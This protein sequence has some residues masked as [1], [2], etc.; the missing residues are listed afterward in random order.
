MISKASARE[1]VSLKTSDTILFG[2]YFQS[3]VPIEDLSEDIRETITGAEYVVLYR[4][5]SYISRS[6]C[7]TR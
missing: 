1:T 7:R 3:K 2:S 4:F 5:S 6:I